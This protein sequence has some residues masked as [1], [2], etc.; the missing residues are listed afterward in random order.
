M[1]KNFTLFEKLKSV[2]QTADSWITGRTE[3]PALEGINFVHHDYQSLTNLLENL[4]EKYPHIC[5]LT[6]LGKSVE[7]REIWAMEISD[8]PGQKELLE[9]EFKYVANMHGN[10]VKGRE[11]AIVLIQYLLNNYGKK[12]RI[13]KIVDD[14][15]IFII[16]SLN[17]DGNQKAFNILRLVF[18]RI[19]LR[20]PVVFHGGS[21][22]PCMWH[23]RKK[24]Y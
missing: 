15:R 20:L 18:S 21:T 13:K 10:E 5:K 1:F 19:F 24:V 2:P 16:P 8:N 9:P 6:T 14:T 4:A 23:F 22:P 11:V 12:P 7:S 3:D 17:P